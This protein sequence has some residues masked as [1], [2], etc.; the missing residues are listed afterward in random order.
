[1]RTANKSSKMPYA[2]LVMQKEKWSGIRIR[3]R[4]TTKS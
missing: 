2:A 3:D 4:I 1:M